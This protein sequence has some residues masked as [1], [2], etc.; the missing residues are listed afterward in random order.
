MAQRDDRLHPAEPSGPTRR[1]YGEVF[2]A[3]W[4]A[5]LAVCG[6][7]PRWSVTEKDP[8]RGEIGVLAGRRWGRAPRAGG[9]RVSLDEVGLTRVE[10]AFVGDRGEPDPRANRREVRRFFRL[11]DR[12]LGTASHP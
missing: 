2:G 5:A 1:V 9:I 11:L 8:A 3:V 4:L 10:V 12:A 7:F 6:R